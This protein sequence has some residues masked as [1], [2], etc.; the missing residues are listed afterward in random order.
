[1]RAWVERTDYAGELF[2]E[3]EVHVTSEDLAEVRAA[4]AELLRA[5]RREGGRVAVISRDLRGE[6]SAAWE[7]TLEDWQGQVRLEVRP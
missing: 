2:A 3:P 7:L 6:G 4:A 5:A 1:M